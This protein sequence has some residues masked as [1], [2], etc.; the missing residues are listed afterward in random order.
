[1]G[2]AFSM[3]DASNEVTHKR[4]LVST[5]C[6]HR[7]VLDSQD[8]ISASESLGQQGR[9]SEATHSPQLPCGIVSNGAWATPPPL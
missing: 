7:A 5:L 8:G 4:A 6:Q 1:M 2:Q 3:V 9:E